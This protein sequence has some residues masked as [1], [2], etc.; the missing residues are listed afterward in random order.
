M[1]EGPIRKFIRSWKPLIPREKI[2]GESLSSVDAEIEAR[3]AQWR[4]QGYTE[5]MIENAQ[6]LARE[7]VTSMASALAPPELQEPVLRYNI[8]KALN[9]AESWLKTMGVAEK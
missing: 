5:N 7:W 6:K 4:A 8:K 9:M 1:S 3:K 2:L